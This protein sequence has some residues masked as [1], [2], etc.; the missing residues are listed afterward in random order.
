MAAALD[1]A[2]GHGRTAI[3]HAAPDEHDR[4]SNSGKL[5]SPSPGAA[6]STGCRTVAADHSRPHAAAQRQRGHMVSARATCIHATNDSRIDPGRGCGCRTHGAHRATGCG[7]ELA[8]RAPESK[9]TC[10]EKA[11][12]K[13]N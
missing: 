13:S 4:K 11:D 2:G 9:L 5:C 7:S 8:A 1:G 10:T 3:D 12:A 6:Q